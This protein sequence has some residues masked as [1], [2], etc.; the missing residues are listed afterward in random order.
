MAGCNGNGITEGGARHILLGPCG[1]Q[2][3]RP[4]ERE[5]DAGAGSKTEGFKPFAEPRPPDAFREQVGSD[6][7][8]FDE[9][10][11]GREAC[12]ASA[13]ADRRN[14][15]FGVVTVP[16]GVDGEGFVKTD[17]PIGE[18][19]RHRGHFDGGTGFVHVIGQVVHAG[20]GGFPA[21]AEVA[22]HEGAEG[23]GGWFEEGDDDNIGVHA[24][25]ADVVGIGG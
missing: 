15:V 10:T 5:R 4:F 16:V 7:A 25:D 13:V 20:P 14:T 2:P 22:C 21:L 18:G 8:G 24:A 19:S 17:F 12:V 23:H 1:P 3:R 9:D 6:V 11:F